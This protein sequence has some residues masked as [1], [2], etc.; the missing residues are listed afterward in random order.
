MIFTKARK[1]RRRLG[2]DDEPPKFPL[3]DELRRRGGT[4]YFAMQTGFGKAA[5]LGPVDR[6]LS[7]WL[8]DAPEGFSDAHLTAI[9]Q[10]PIFASA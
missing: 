5:S 9:E 10:I 3:F 2:R 1:L 6:I 4:D 8:T 7:S